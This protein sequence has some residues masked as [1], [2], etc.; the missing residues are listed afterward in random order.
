M[1]AAAALVGLLCLI[2]AGEAAAAEAGWLQQHLAEAV[3][4]I[5]PTLRRWG[6]PAIGA[7]VALDYVGVPLPADTMLVAATVASTRGDLAL[8]AVYGLAVIAM[9]LGSQAGFALGRWGGRALL[10]RLPVAPAHVTAVEDRYRRWGTW[11]VLVAP[12]IDGLRQLNAFAAGMLGMAWWRFTTVNA[13]AAVI[14]AAAWIGAA[15]L[16]ADHVA[17]ILP[18]LRAAKPWLY[19]AAVAALGWWLWRATRE[20]GRDSSR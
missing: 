11:V 9:I 1:R 18:S 20:P 2:L 3:R 6:Y 19:L 15:F 7:V 13:V 12:F 8:G 4:E 17:G 5:E 14:W 16:L 10:E